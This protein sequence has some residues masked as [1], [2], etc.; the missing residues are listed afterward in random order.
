[1][2][3][4]PRRPLWRLILGVLLMAYG[5]LM[6]AA[7]VYG[8]VLMGSLAALGLGPVLIGVVALFIGWRLYRVD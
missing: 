7:N 3:D 1:M 2:A 4:E 6:L 5:V 8:M